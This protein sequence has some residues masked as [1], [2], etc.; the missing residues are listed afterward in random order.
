MNQKIYAHL[1]YF[2]CKLFVSVAASIWPSLQDIT[3][4]GV[5]FFGVFTCLHVHSGS[6]GFSVIIVFVSLKMILLL[7][8]VNFLELCKYIPLYLE[9]V[10]EC[11]FH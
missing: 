2:P 9:K 7:L 10:N 8:L 6:A 3:I 5:I 1:V 4:V 11:V